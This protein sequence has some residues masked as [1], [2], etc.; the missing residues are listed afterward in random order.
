MRLD[1]ACRR[2]E[3]G[4]TKRHGGG[5][6]PVVADVYESSD[7]KTGDILASQRVRQRA[8]NPFANRRRPH[9]LHHNLHRHLGCPSF[10]GQDYLTRE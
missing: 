9:W 3:R 6:K 5:E 8:V 4:S 10:R 7:A 1:C 2:D